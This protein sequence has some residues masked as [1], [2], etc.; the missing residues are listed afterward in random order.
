MLPN[1]TNEAMTSF[2]RSFLSSSFPCNQTSIILK[3]NEKI[4]KSCETKPEEAI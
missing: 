2:I 4:P 3:K 1:L